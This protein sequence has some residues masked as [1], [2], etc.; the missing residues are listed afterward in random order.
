MVY[1]T[2]GFGI[3]RALHRLE[4]FNQYA[5]ARRNDSELRRG[6][7]FAREAMMLLASTADVSLGWLSSESTIDSIIT[8]ASWVL[9]KGVIICCPP[10]EEGKV[11]VSGTP[12]KISDVPPQGQV[13]VDL[14]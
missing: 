3:C 4:P 5:C 14:L 2:P 6:G 10:E 1:H 8:L 12:N 9:P 7:W 11:M 13:V